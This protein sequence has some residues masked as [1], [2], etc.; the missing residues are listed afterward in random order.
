MLGKPPDRR[1]G[2]LGNLEA[3][4][5]GLAERLDPHLSRAC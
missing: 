1:L 2:Q 3:L 5:G 4:H